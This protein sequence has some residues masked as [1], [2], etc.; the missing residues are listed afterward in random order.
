MLFHS[1]SYLIFTI[2]FAAHAK[3]TS[4][5]A[6]FSSRVIYQSPDSLFI[7]NLAVR[8]SSELLLTSVASPTLFALDPTTING[9]LQPVHTFGNTNSLSGITEYHSGVRPNIGMD[10]RF[11]RANSTNGLTAM[12]SDP[13]TLLLADSF[14]GV[15]WQIDARTGSTRFALQEPTMLPGGPGTLGIN[16]IHVRDEYLYFINLQQTTFAR[17]PLCVEH[18]NL[19]ARGATEILSTLGTN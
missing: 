9:T 4:K 12:P 3:P 2:F 16:G 19:T 7:E 10:P 11:G 14:E 13:G 6:T 18:G 17:L 5:E 15:V 8:A 1:F